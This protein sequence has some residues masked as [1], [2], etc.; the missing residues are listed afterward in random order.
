MVST[1]VCFYQYRRK[2][3]YIAELRSPNKVRGNTPMTSVTDYTIIIQC[4]EYFY[5]V[6]N[7]TI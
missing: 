3:T 6:T 7:V 4:P 1:P 2:L 5:N